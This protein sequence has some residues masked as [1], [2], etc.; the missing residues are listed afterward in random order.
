MIGFLIL[1][2]EENQKE[3]YMMKNMLKK[4]ISVHSLI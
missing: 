3:G 2:G 4:M 1:G